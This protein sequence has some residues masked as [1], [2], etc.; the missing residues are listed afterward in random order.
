MKQEEK[1]EFL[2]NEQKLEGLEN[3]KV[4]NPEKGKGKSK[5]GNDTAAFA[6]AA[7]VGG[8]AMGSITTEL[9]EE[10]IVDTSENV[11]AQAEV[12]KP[13]HAETPAVEQEGELPAE[14]PVEQQEEKIEETPSEE[15]AE[16]TPTE[17]KTEEQQE[18]VT[19]ETTNEGETDFA[20]NTEEIPV[21]EVDENGVEQL[22]IAEIAPMEITPQEEAVLHADIHDIDVVVT[23]DEPIDGQIPGIDEP[24]HQIELAYQEKNLIDTDEFENRVFSVKEKTILQEGETAI[25]AVNIVDAD[26]NEFLLADKDGDGLYEAV[27]DS[28]G[29]LQDEDNFSDGPESSSDVLIYDEDDS[30]VDDIEGLDVGD[31]DLV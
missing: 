26:G 6:A 25:P 10:G 18:E 16:M 28:D 1:K 4:E 19:E 17:E 3:Q 31:T 22:D 9:P 14:E 5:K 20:E 13:S 7:V 27:Y 8:A 12:V 15:G 29:I 24:N 30:I 23:P 21:V 11:V 2:A